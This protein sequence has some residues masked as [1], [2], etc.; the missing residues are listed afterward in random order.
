MIPTA[1]AAVS[2]AYRAFYQTQDW[3]TLMERT[4]DATDWG[5]IVEND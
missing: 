2:H 5:W 1:S 4:L 3:N